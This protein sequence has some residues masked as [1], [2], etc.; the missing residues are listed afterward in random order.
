MNPK[1]MF[2]KTNIPFNSYELLLTVL[3]IIS[4]CICTVLLTFLWL[5]NET[6]EQGAKDH[7]A[8]GIFTIKSGAM[9]SPALQNKSSVDFKILA[10]D[11]QQMVD[12]MLHESELQNEYKGSKVTQFRNGSVIV[13]F[14][15]FFVQWVSE[16]KIKNALVYGIKEN[17]SELLQTLTIDVNSIEIIDLGIFTTSSSLTTSGLEIFSTTTPGLGITSTTSNPSTTPGK[18]LP[19]DG[20]CA[21]DIT[22]IRKE[23]FCDGIPHCPDGSDENKCATPCDGKFILDGLSGSFHSIHYPEPYSSNL[24]CRWIINMEKHLSIKIN[25]TSFET[26]KYSDFLSIYE[27]IGPTKILRAETSGSNP[28]TI[29]I[30]SDKATVEFVT[31]L[32]KNLNGFNATYTAFNASELT[33]NEK[34]NCTFEDG[35]CYWIQHIKDRTEWERT[36]GPVFPTTGPD[37][38]HTFGNLSGYYIL[39]LTYRTSEQLRIEIFSLPL[40]PISDAYCLS[41]WYYMYGIKIYRLNVKIIYDDNSEKIIFQKEGNYGNIW[42]YGQIT[43]NETSKFKVA[44]EALKRYY[45]NDIALDDIG[46]SNGACAKSI[47]PEPTLV[48]TI[49]TTFLL[50]TDCGGPYDLWEPNTTF[51]SINYPNNYPSKA[52]C[53]W[54]LNAE[55]GK[56]IQLHFQYFNLED[57]YDVVEVR[58]GRG[59][60]SLFLAVYTGKSPLPDIFSTTHQMTVLFITDKS[61]TRKGFVANFTTGYHLGMPVHLINGSLSSNGLVQYKI[62]TQWYTA[63]ANEWTE[64]S[65]TTICNLLKLGTG[66]K[67]SPVLY[68]GAGPFVEVKKAANNSFML[69]PRVKCLNNLVIHLQCS[70]KS[71]G[72]KMITQKSRPRIVGGSDAQEGA[73]P[74]IVSLYFNYRPTCGASLINNEWLLSAAHCVYGRNLKPSQW[75]AVLGLHTNLNLSYPQ[76]VSREIDQI[77][78]NP[79]YNKRTKDSDIALMHLQFRVN[80]TDYIQPICFPEKNKQFLPGTKCSIA[81]WGKTTP[82]DSISSIL[83]EAEVPLITHQ[84]CK[85]LMPEYNITENMICAGYDKGGI[86]SCQGDSG[87]PLMCQ[88]NKK[89][90]LAGV[91]SFGY[92]CALPNRPGIYV[93]VFKFVDW[94]KRTINY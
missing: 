4:L 52:S 77:I 7:E 32:N 34:I 36:D 14:K 6:T 89:W 18:C 9:F 24:V 31:D 49:P 13:F 57:I 79:H 86:D 30:F 90:F 65:S 21:D 2:K 37:F 15:L 73:W 69:K 61:V 27:G 39:T 20:L 59:A 78:I 23:L 29:Y 76:T 68:T 94:I 64:A 66:N 82:E 19:L 58:D 50:P 22:C 33:N 44:F 67:S 12:D 25:F 47:Y 56:N 38:D 1:K 71:C 83:Q 54:Y 91:T 26:Q 51:T 81:G 8:M 84:K 62:E 28:G 11:V 88:E 16:V 40:D 48:P 41:F 87:G 93:N 43:L 75:K 45:W 42:N 70:G 17:K 85:E 60:E 80:Y 10:F 63:C 92:K 72:E 53:V 3:F 55:K 35:F 46:L 74:W 5:F